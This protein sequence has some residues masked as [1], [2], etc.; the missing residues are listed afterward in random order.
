MA[1][2]TPTI[3]A[4]TSP[5]HLTAPHGR[6]NLTLVTPAP[7]R[8]PTVKPERDPQGRIEIV[9]LGTGDRV[10]LGPQS[11]DDAVGA[12]FAAGDEQALALSFE[13][14]AALVRGVALRNLADPADA[15]DA[16]QQVFVKAWRTRQSFDPSRGPLA[17]W[18]V[19]VTRHVCADVWQQ[20]A[21]QA[22]QTQAAQEVAGPEVAPLT[23][24]PERAVDRLVVLDALTSVEHPAREIIELAFFHDLT[25]KQIAERLDL[26][27]GTVKSHMRRALEALQRE[28]EDSRVHS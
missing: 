7:N 10:P 13:R 11:P 4:A 8:Q 24:S 15:D 16:T 20:R 12:A 5:R 3:T 25:H 9:G 17:G 21:R 23:E 19:G 28:L 22:R 18:L 14:W 2:A 26:P 1:A 27:L 6:P